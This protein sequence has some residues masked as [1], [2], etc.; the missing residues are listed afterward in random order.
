MTP[1]C[2]K[3]KWPLIDAYSTEHAS[4]RPASKCHRFLMSRLIAK[5]G[6]VARFFLSLVPLA[7]RNIYR[8]DT[9]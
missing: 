5:T 4:D 2:R 7:G 9:V 1:R 6:E 3:A 8:I